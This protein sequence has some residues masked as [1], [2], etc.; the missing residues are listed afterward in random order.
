MND[1]VCR[2]V[3]SLKNANYVDECSINLS[4]DERYKSI[5]DQKAENEEGS[6]R[7]IYQRSQEWHDIRNQ[8]VVTGSTLYKAVGCDGLGKQKD[9][10]DKVICGVAEK[11]P[12]E[13]I[14]QMMQ[15]GIDNENNGVATLVGKVMP[16]LSPELMFCEEGCVVVENEKGQTFM[17][18]SPDGS[19]RH[20]ISLSSSQIA[21]EIKCPTKMVHTK[22]PERYLLQCL[23]EMHALNV[24]RLLYLS[25][26]ENVTAVFEVMRND[27]LL[28]KALKISMELYGA[29]KPKKPTKLTQG[30]Y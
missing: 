14:K 1:S 19:L 8:A 24:Q 6:T 21:I 9:H 29:E 11:E 5:E 25:L 10:F 26:T 13:S 16:V 3:A 7:L 22:F 4:L 2:H 20:D 17:V 15:H 27:R 18:V 12:S 23:A 28:S 30:T